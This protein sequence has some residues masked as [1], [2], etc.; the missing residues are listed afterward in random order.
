MTKI[1][2]ILQSCVQTVNL[3]YHTCM[4]AKMA[5]FTKIGPV[6]FACACGMFQAYCSISSRLSITVSGSENYNFYNIGK[7]CQ[8]RRN[9][10]RIDIEF[11]KVD[12][13][14]KIF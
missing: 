14:F 9:E 6:I 10:M 4:Q 3:W 13:F 11:S 5:S 1:I 12:K 2:F 8:I 7:S